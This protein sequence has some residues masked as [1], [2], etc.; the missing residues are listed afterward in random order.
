MAV[1]K[2][3][4]GINSLSFHL[5][6]LEKANFSPR[7]ICGNPDFFFLTKE[8]KENQELRRENQQNQTTL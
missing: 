6:K 5:R 2:K 4:I 8:K 3:K 1:R 7:L